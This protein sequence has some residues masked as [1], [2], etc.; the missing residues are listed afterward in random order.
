MLPKK[1][2]DAS[3]EAAR[4]YAAKAGY[5]GWKHN[6]AINVFLVGVDA[7]VREYYYGGPKGEVT[8]F[9]AHYAY[10]A[11]A[12]WWEQTGKHVKEGEVVAS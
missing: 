4:E 9:I 2:F 3:Q 8:D 7:K 10:Q 5:E 1:A 12:E 11:G 6:H